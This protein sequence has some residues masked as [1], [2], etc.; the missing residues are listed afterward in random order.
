MA[1]TM[2]RLLSPSPNLRSRDQPF[3]ALRWRS[4]DHKFTSLDY[5]FY[6]SR[7]QEFFKQPHARAALEI[8][9]IIGRLAR[10]SI[11]QDVALLGPALDD[12]YV[13]AISVDG[14]QLWGDRVSDND[15]DIISGVYKVEQNSGMSPYLS[16]RHT[17]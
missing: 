17:C 1:F 6:V 15:L 13:Q 12:G 8:G 9:G 10:E 5:G 2:H 11:G 4:H 14:E 7:R 3:E 16:A